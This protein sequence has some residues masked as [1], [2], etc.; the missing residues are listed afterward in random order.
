MKKA[1]VTILFVIVSTWIP[2]NSSYAWEFSFDSALVNFRFVY[3]S[4]SGSRGFFGPFNTDQSSTGGDFASFNGW[5]KKRLLS[6]TTALASSTRLAIFPVLKLHR[7][8]SVTGTYRIEPDDTENVESLVNPDF[9]G[10]LSTGRWTRL[11][12]TVNTPLGKLVYGRRG[13][14]QGCGL[15]FSATELAEDIFDTANRIVDIVQFETYYGPFTFAFGFYPRKRGS[16]L[17]WNFEDQNSARS[18]HLLGYLRYIGHN[19]D[20][21][22]GG[23]YFLF[24]EGPEGE[25]SVMRRVSTPPSNTSGTEGWAYVKYTDGRLFFNVEAD[26]YLTTLRFQ[27]SQDGTFRGHPAI[28]FPGGGSHFAPKYVESL[29]YMFEFGGYSR[30]IKLSFLLCHL[31]GPDR[32][33]GILIDRQPF[34]QEPEKSAFAVTNPYCLLM[35]KYYRAGVDSYLD[36]SA[37]DMVAVQMNY[38]IASNFNLVTA[39]AYARRSSYGYGIGYINPEAESLGHLEFKN[40]GTFS[41]PAPSI[42]DNDLGWE[43]GVGT[44]WRLLENWELSCR[45]AYWQPGKWFTFACIDKSVPNWDNPSSANNWGVNP[46]RSIDPIKGLEIFLNV[47]M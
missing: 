18:A 45:A 12:L 41:N 32:R 7:A 15:Q 42:P 29:R 4:Q 36:M 31:P 10:F 40:K 47:K 27:K 26:W 6:G 3:A 28:P 20:M 21:G 17:Y 38:L 16:L 5:F 1:I 43:F 25:T 30:S 23:F 46:N 37:S 2:L 14:Q 39:L 22:F 24:D 8:V 35:G 11:W 33:H 9:E 19:V 44:V 34:I 13:F